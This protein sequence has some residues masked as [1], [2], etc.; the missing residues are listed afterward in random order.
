MTSGF[1]F[2][3]SR[4]CKKFRPLSRQSLIV[5][6]NICGCEMEGRGIYSETP[7]NRVK[8]YMN[9]MNEVCRLRDTHQRTPSVDILHPAVDLF[10]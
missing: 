9:L 5:I 10:V 4:G 2:G 3:D 1:F 6:V 7:G 8:S